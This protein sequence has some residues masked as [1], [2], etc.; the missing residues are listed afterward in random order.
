MKYF[1]TIF[2]HLLLWAT[3]GMA[4]NNAVPVNFQLQT[5]DLLFCTSTSGELSRAIDQATQTIHQTHFDH[6]G[7]VEVDK[8]TV[9]VIHA[10]PK[11]G[12]CREFISQFLASDNGQVVPTVYRL[13]AKYQKAIPAAIQ[14][15]RKYVGQTYNY[16]YK[17]NEKGFY[18]SEFIYVI[19]TG[20]SIFTLNPMTFKNPETGRT[21]PG[22]INHYQK[23]GIPVPEGEPGCNPNGLAT[24]EKLEIIGVVKLT[25]CN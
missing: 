13:K 2:I 15:A 17:L 22:W 8:D 12:V 1:M 5:G 6:V 11:K 18:C 4:Q 25:G 3:M 14:N 24:S 20:D 9:R 19:F 23:L 7:I 10:A 16:T 21:I